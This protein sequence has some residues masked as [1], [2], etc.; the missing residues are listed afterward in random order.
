MKIS[1]GMRIYIV[2]EGFEV[3]DYGMPRCEPLETWS[4]FCASRKKA[5]LVGPSQKDRRARTSS[6]ASSTRMV[7][8]SRRQRC[9]SRVGRCDPEDLEYRYD[10]PGSGC[11][12]KSSL[13]S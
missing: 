13:R 11:Q 12:L 10:D 5:T 6:G 1:T 3:P 2:E 4:I 7:Q 8:A 9:A